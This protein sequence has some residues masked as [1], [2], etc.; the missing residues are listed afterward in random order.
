MAARMPP[1]RQVSAGQWKAFL[2]T[3]AAWVL[4]A[5]DFAILTFVLADIQQSF[6][7]RR[8]RGSS[9]RAH[10]RCCSRPLG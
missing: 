9:M 6:S 10:R 5:F 8:C 3:F 4:D 1:L 2:A 7:V